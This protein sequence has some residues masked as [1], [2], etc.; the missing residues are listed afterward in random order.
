MIAADQVILPFLQNR[1][2]PTYVLSNFKGGFTSVPELRVGLK[3]LF[4]PAAL[5][6]R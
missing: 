2:A 4:R 5:A 1:D 6:C 3:F